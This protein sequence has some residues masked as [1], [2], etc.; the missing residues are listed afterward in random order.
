MAPICISMARSG[1]LGIQRRRS[2]RAKEPSR[3]I[4]QLHSGCSWKIL[5]GHD[6][7]AAAARVDLQYFFSI[8]ASE[9]HRPHQGKRDT[10]GEEKEGESSNFVIYTDYTDESR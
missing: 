6:R 1:S 9:D 5:Q 2:A 7:C 10:V 3:W 4:L 8:G